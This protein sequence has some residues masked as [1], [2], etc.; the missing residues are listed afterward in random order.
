MQ[1]LLAYVN[2]KGP[3][4]VTTG[5]HNLLVIGSAA[6]VWEDLRRYD[7]KHAQ[8]DRMAVNDMMAYYPGRLQYGVTLHGNKLPGW[9]FGQEY[10]AT[11]GGWPLLEVHSNLHWPRIDQVWPL[12]RDGGTSGIFGAII[13]LLMGYDKVILAGIPADGSPR[14][15]DPPWQ[16]HPQFSLEHVFVEWTRLYESVPL[17]REQIRSLSGRTKELWGEPE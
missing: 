17:A 7:E 15:F 8:Q 9:V 1:Q 10:R 3:L 11:M 2:P 12:Q 13:G 16:F 14:F 6:C 5:R 4:P